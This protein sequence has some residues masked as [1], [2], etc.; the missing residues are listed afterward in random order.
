MTRSRAPRSGC[1]G[2]RSGPATSWATTS[3][4]PPAEGR[5]TTASSRSRRW[6]RSTARFAK[7]WACWAQIGKHT[8]E[9]QSHHDLP[10][11]PTRR[12]SDLVADGLNVINDEVSSTSFR[13]SRAAIGPRNFVGNYVV[14]PA[15]G[16]TGDN[17]LL[18]IKAMV[19]I[20]GQVREGVGLLGS[21]RK[22]H[23]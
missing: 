18:A 21:D 10:S 16:R 11:F 9:L 1:P 6:S 8:S 23:V 22:A 2:R 13:V 19:P 4:T 17:C 3:S 15:G 7:G 5:A 14:Y 20:D 12:S